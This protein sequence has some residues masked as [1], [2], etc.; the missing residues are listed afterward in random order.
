MKLTYTYKGLLAAIVL[1]V[2]GGGHLQGRA[3]QE[4]L[5][6]VQDTLEAVQDS[7]QAV[8][9]TLQADSTWQIERLAP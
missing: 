3:V 5:L 7:V 6:V 9:D 8:P 2:S 4:T 1:L